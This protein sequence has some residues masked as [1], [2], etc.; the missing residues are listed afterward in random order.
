[1][2]VDRIENLVNTRIKIVS[3]F[4]IR[5]WT[6]NWLPRANVQCRT[7]WRTTLLRIQWTPQKRKLCAVTTKGWPL[8]ASGLD[9]DGQIVGTIFE[10]VL[11]LVL[12][13]E[14]W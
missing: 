2:A 12:T 8:N 7:H 9:S 1:M 10:F 14:D 5:S 13:I 6:E 11:K 3:L 4:G